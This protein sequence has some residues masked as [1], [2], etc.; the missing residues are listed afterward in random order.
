MSV[1]LYRALHMGQTSAS[2]VLAHTLL[3]KPF[4]LECKP[5]SLDSRGISGFP[6]QYR[7]LSHTAHRQ[8]AVAGEDH[9]RP[10][11]PRIRDLLSGSAR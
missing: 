3:G 4:L 2:D 7:I 1:K 10:V 8:S 11:L 6:A 9:I 5:K